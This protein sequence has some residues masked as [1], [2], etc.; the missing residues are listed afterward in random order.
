MSYMNK[1]EESITVRV[2]KAIKRQLA[3]LAASQH[4]G[5]I[6]RVVRR[7]ILDGLKGKE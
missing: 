1:K 5:S 2:G 7:L 3:H 4:D 6:S